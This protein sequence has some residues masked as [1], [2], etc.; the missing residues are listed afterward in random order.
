M[1]AE[2]EAQQLRPMVLSGAKLG[3]S[4]DFLAAMSHSGVD[5]TRYLDGGCCGCGD[6]DAPGEQSRDDDLGEDER[7]RPMSTVEQEI[8][9]GAALRNP[10]AAELRRKAMILAA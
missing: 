4:I 8:E 7:A 5:G 1:D 2:E 3:L 6:C 10:A 9:R